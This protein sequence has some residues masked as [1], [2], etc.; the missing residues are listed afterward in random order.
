M[1][2]TFNLEETDAI[3]LAKFQ[4]EQSNYTAELIRK[5]RTWYFVAFGLLA[6]GSWLIN[7]DLVLMICFSSTAVLFLFITPFVSRWNVNRSI[8]KL[9]RSRLGKTALGDKTMI[10]SNDGLAYRS[11]GSQTLMRWDLVDGVVEIDDHV[12]IAFDGSYTI[13][14]PKREVEATTLTSFL[15]EIRSRVSAADAA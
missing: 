15:D 11:A 9:V 8:P 6:L 12:F 1:E 7:R 2:I 4:M 5:R 13:V 10:V 14:I 3:A